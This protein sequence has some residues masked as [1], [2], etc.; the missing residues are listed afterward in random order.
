VPRRNQQAQGREREADPAHRRAN[1]MTN[2]E[3]FE[4]FWKERKGAGYTGFG[5]SRDGVYLTEFVRDAWAA[6]EAAQKPT[7][8]AE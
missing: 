8:R 4:S 3:R 6:W 1:K 2:Q 7:E 5:K